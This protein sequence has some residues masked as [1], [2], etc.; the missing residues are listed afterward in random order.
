MNQTCASVSVSFVKTPPKRSLYRQNWSKTKSEA[1]A[2]QWPGCVLTVRQKLHQALIEET[3]HVEVVRWQYYIPEDNFCY[4]LCSFNS[5]K[6]KPTSGKAF[7]R[8]LWLLCRLDAVLRVIAV[9]GSFFMSQGW[10]SA[11]ATCYP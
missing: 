11:G 2:S 1:R 4:L 7:P 6:P 9:A 3:A 5:T 10:I 8:L